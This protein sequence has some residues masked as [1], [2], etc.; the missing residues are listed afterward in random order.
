MVASL[1][2]GFRVSV[3]VTGRADPR[4]TA[5]R[6]DAD[7]V[8]VAGQIAAAE[9]ALDGLCVDQFLA[10]EA[11]FLRVAVLCHAMRGRDAGLWQDEENNN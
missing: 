11:A 3:A 10:V 5:G 7:A 8:L 2:L 4:S 1:R 6:G 9:A